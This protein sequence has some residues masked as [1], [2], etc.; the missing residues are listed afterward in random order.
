MCSKK[1][2][3]DRYPE[4]IDVFI[5]SV[6]PQVK[7]HAHKLQ[8]KSHP[9][10]FKKNPNH[11]LLIKNITNYLLQCSRI[12]ISSHMNFAPSTS[13]SSDTQPLMTSWFGQLITAKEFSRNKKIP[14]TKPNLF[15]S[16]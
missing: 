3:H 8:W 4:L 9:F 1:T 10:L 14:Q 15:H 13:F 2:I 11:L 5:K 12:G 7:L 16:T 6:S